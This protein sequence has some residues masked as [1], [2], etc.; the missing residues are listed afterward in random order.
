VR[1]DRLRADVRCE[2]LVAQARGDVL[3]LSAEPRWMTKADLPLHG[4]DTVVSVFQLCGI[5]DVFS[6]LLRIAEL[7]RPNGQLLLLEHVRATGWRGR[8]QDAAA[9]VPGTC[10]PNRDVVALLRANGFA[11]T[12]CDRYVLE[13]A[14]P[15]V[16]H[17]VSAVAIRKVRNEVTG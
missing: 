13:G 15:L 10:Y 4:Y 5:E 3:D 2:R 17:A 9:R 12:D 16:R 11:V 14:T 7:L 1:H 8:I 6:A